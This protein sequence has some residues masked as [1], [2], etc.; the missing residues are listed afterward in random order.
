MRLIA[1][2]CL[3]RRVRLGRIRAARMAVNVYL[4]F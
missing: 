1:L 3:Y 2:Y 4:T